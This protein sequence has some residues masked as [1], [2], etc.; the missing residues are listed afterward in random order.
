MSAMAPPP[1]PPRSRRPGRREYGSGTFWGRPR[2]QGADPHRSTA[3]TAPANARAWAEV[4]RDQALRR[5]AVPWAAHRRTR[6][7]QAERPPAAGNP[8][9]FPGLRAPPGSTGR[10]LQL[11]EAP[12]PR[13]ITLRRGNQQRI[14]DDLAVRSPDSSREILRAIGVDQHLRT[15]APCR[16]VRLLRHVP[17]LPPGELPLKLASALT[18][19]HGLSPPST[20]NNTPIPRP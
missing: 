12:H 20:L 7:R 11:A 18:V 9:P 4:A 2:R 19:P 15:S 17:D 8:P 3:V 13:R 5:L 6:P 14:R 10:L 1:A 16:T